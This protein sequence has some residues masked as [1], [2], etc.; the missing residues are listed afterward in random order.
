M[1]METIA[2]LANHHILQN[3]DPLIHDLD[4]LAETISFPSPLSTLSTPATF[5]TSIGCH[6]SLPWSPA[7]VFLQSI[8]GDL[9]LPSPYMSLPYL[10]VFVDVF[11]GLGHLHAPPKCPQSLL[12]PPPSP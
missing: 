2:D 1:V 11:I 12:D 8:V 5:D 10:D 4:D 6:K 7:S 3:M 9:S